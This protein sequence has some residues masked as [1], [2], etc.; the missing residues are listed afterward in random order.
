MQSTIFDGHGPFLLPGALG[1]ART[2]LAAGGAP[3]L[4][5]SHHALNTLYFCPHLYIRDAR[6][7]Y[8]VVAMF[9]ICTEPAPSIAL[10]Q[11]ARIEPWDGLLGPWTILHVVTVAR[12]HRHHTLLLCMYSSCKCYVCLKW[13]T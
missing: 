10:R 5:C 3:V 9:A 2:L 8:L 12:G 13:R 4:A 1:L 7:V 11:A 6:F